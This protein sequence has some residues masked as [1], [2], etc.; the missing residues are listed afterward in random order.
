MMD[1]L[2][3]SGSQG[4]LAAKKQRYLEIARKIEAAVEAGDLSTEEAEKK[5]IAVRHDMFEQGYDG[6]HKDSRM[7]AKKRTYMEA[8]EKIEAEVKTGAL[9]KE[10]AKDR[11][12]ELKKRLFSDGE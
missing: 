12:V 8:A 3:R 4:E 1:A 11:L 10:A 9:T 5:L 6:D 2:R 7:E